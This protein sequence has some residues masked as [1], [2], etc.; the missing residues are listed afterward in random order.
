MDMNPFVAR[1]A[2]DSFNT[3]TTPVAFAIPSEVDLCLTMTV[4]ELPTKPKLLVYPNPASEVVTFQSEMPISTLQMRN[5]FGQTIV[6]I[7]PLKKNV[8]LNTSGYSKG[9]YFYRVTIGKQII[10]GKIVLY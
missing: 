3:I 8:S 9:I 10:T 6:D 1:S 4:N 7:Y 5:S 2:I